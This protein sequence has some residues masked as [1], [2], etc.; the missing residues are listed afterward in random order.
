[1]PT[2]AMIGIDIRSAG[3]GFEAQSPAALTA[4]VASKIVKSA[5]FALFTA[6][7]ACGI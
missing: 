6:C 2:A 1:M 4:P 5:N 3:R 7:I